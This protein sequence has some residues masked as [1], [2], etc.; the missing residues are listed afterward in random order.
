MGDVDVSGDGSSGVSHDA[1]DVVGATNAAWLYKLTLPFVQTAALL[2][3]L[4]YQSQQYDKIEKS[5]QKYL[6]A[7]GDAW[8]EC[9]TGVMD[10]VKLATDDV[11]E[12]AVFQPVQP[13]GQQIETLKSNQEAICYGKKMVKLMNEF[14]IEN[15]IARAVSLNPKYYQNQELKC[16]SIQ[17]LLR[18][19]MSVGKLINITTDIAQ[20]D[21]INGK[22]GLNKKMT[23]RMIG[24]EVENLQALGRSETRIEDQNNNQNI[25]PLG[26]MINLDTYMLKPQDA[27]TFALQ[28]ALYIQQ[29]CQN[30]NNA[31]ARKDP[32]LQK[33][34]DLMVAK[35]TNQMQINALKSGAVNTFVPNYA[36]IF[37]SQIQDFSTGL[38]GGINGVFSD[39][40]VNAQGQ[41][42]AGFGSYGQ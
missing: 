10:F 20:N 4:N 29:S 39:G 26:R 1:P 11:P 24:I 6:Q 7:T 35:C 21:V 8:C 28:Q 12:P 34:A 17:A 41:S 22:F 38:A 33:Q 36:A 16:T 2:P 40:T 5:K 15:D 3:I 23:A 18:G 27:L 32:Y 25:S 37:Q 31:Y 19:E 13:A 14:H 9:I 42:I 30:E